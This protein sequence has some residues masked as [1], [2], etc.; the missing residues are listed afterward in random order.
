MASRKALN[1]IVQLPAKRVW[2]TRIPLA[3]YDERTLQGARGYI[4]PST[5]QQSYEP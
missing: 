3:K 1:N 4:H 5:S 2:G